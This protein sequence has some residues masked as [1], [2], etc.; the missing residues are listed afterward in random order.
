MI[1]VLTSF[2][3]NPARAA[4]QQTCIRSWS[5]A[6]C[7]IRAVYGAGEQVD[8]GPWSSEIL[9]RE[10]PL[11]GPTNLHHIWQFGASTTGWHLLLNSDIE[12]APSIDCLDSLRDQVGNG[13]LIIR[14]QNYDPGT[15][16]AK[17]L[18]EMAGIDGFF[19]HFD[20]LQPFAGTRF[21][22]GRPMWDYWLAS[23]FLDAGRVVYELRDCVA[24]H[25]NHPR[26]WEMAHAGD[27]IRHCKDPTDRVLLNTRYLDQARD[28]MFARLCA[29]V[30]PINF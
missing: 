8:V 15:D 3:P 21:A 25:E 1:R 30:Q 4:R 18:R 20:G 2:S 26:F 5:D 24:Y 27:M 13:L 9:W 17:G 14:R 11:P 23:F 6:G 29:E 22:I 12:L 19:C 7:T 28:Q 10:S 16:R